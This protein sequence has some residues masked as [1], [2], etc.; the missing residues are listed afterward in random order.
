MRCHADK[1]IH[2]LRWFEALS[3]TFATG[4]AREVFSGGRGR[5]IQGFC[6]TGRLGRP[7]VKTY[8]LA[9]GGGVHR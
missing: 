2:C 4:P 3:P 7:V 6:D 5:W 9:G 1:R 8:P